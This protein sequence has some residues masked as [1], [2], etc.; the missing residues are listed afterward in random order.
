MLHVPTLSRYFTQLR[1]P[2]AAFFG[3]ESQE[4]GSGLATDREVDVTTGERDNCYTDQLFHGVLPNFALSVRAVVQPWK[5]GTRK[6][7]S[8]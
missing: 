3:L 8:V 1:L 6:C 5:P 7:I 2:D 4:L